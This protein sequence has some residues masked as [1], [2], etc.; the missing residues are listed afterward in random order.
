MPVDVTSRYWALGSYPALRDGERTTALPARP[1]TPAP[2]DADGDFYNHRV[3]GVETME[4][5]SWRY[6]GSSTA[7][8]QV[9]DANGLVFPLDHRPGTTLRMPPAAGIGRV[10]RTRSL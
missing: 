1:L 5:L 8:W 2:D 7:W 4:Y 9:A 10:M 6:F 3:T